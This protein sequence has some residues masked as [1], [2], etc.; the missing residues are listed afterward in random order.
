MNETQ[1]ATYESLQAGDTAYS[2]G[3]NVPLERV[4]IE[5]ITNTLIIDTKGR[6]YRR[7][8]GMRTGDDVWS[9]YY[10]RVGSEYATQYQRERNIAT[11]R[12]VDWTELSD[13][14]LAQVV[15]VLRGE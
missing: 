3:N 7:G 5:R 2:E 12:N 1:E 10:L 8:G 15:K 4:K 13:E 6:K 11:L 9:H 14:T